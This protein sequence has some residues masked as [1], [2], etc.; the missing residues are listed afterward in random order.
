MRPVAAHAELLEI[1]A[2]D[3]W[4]RWGLS[5]T[6]PEPAWV[7]GTMAVIPRMG[8]RPGFWVTPLVGAVA[9]EQ[10]RAALLWL[11]DSGEIERLSA[12][13]LSVPQEH[14]AIAEDV[15]YLTDGGDWEWMWTTTEPPLDPREALVEELDDREDAEEIS[16]FSHANNPR[17]WTEIGTGRVGRWLGLRDPKGRLIAVGGVEVEDS[18]VPHL[19]GIVTAR[20]HRGQGLG[21]VISAALTR[22]ALAEHGVCTLGMFSDNDTARRVYHR[23][24]YRT[25]RCWNSRRL[26]GAD[27]I[28]RRST[29]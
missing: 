26:A 4:V 29:D 7:D 10:L 25:A 18:G 1:S 19:S 12:S 5:A 15:F 3:P 11:R 24:G 20:E 6:M 9:P 28:P 8:R 13:G 17:V 27:P 2:S 21:S 14:L 22:D 16:A 23:L